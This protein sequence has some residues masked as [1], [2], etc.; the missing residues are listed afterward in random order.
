MGENTARSESENA[1]VLK[2]HFVPLITASDGLS[3][4]CDFNRRQFPE[5]D[6]FVY[7]NTRSTAVVF[8]RCPLETFIFSGCWY[9][10]RQRFSC[11]WSTHQISVPNKVMKHL[12]RI[13]RT[14]KPVDIS[15]VV[16]AQ[17]DLT[18]RIFCRSKKFGQHENRSRLKGWK[19]PQT[20]PEKR[21]K[22]NVYLTSLR[23]S[24]V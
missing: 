16:K 4:R 18:P 5:S 6:S 9:Y 15:R 12:N 17:T 11:C 24:A 19:Q 13:D 2:L 1:T 3:I 22:E 23:F 8:E 21:M 7:P 10:L 14:T 20:N